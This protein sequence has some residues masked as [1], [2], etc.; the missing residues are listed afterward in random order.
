[1]QS[2]NSKYITRIIELIKQTDNYNLVMELA[3]GGSLID[4][5][6]T[7]LFNEEEVNLIIR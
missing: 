7:R 4:L 1:M 6:N 3:N 5:L 2:A